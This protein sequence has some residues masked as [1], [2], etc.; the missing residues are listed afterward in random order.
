[1][2]FR[3]YS[4]S[5]TEPLL[6]KNENDASTIQNMLINNNLILAQT[7]DILTWNGNQWTFTGSIGF[8]GPSGPT[9]ANGNSVLN[10]TINP[11]SFIGVN[12]DFYINTT[13]NT[14][15]GPKSGNTWPPGVST[16][17]YTGSIGFTGPSGPTGTNGNSVLNGTVNPTSFIGVNGDFYIN[18]ATNTIFGPKSGSTWPLGILLDGPTG[19][20]GYATNTGATGP[21]GYT[22]STGPGY[23]IY[24]TTPA[25]SS[26]S[27]G[28]IGPVLGNK[29]VLLGYQAGL[30]NTSLSSDNVGIGYNSLISATSATGNIAIGSSAGQFITTGNNNILI[31]SNAE[32]NTTSYTTLNNSTTSNTLTIG[33]DQQRINIISIGPYNIMKFPVK[34]GILNSIT[35]S[36]LRINILPGEGI[37]LKINGMALSSGTLVSTFETKLAAKNIA[38]VITSSNTT[39][40]VNSGGGNP[41]ISTLY[42]TLSIDIQISITNT[43]NPTYDL[44][45]IVSNYSVS[46]IQIIQ[47]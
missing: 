40:S 25:L 37:G 23:R 43:G 22:G 45:I 46:N 35:T 12:E 24:G 4:K 27:G 21:T 13:T 26:V 33:S 17:G 31:G 39:S 16:E 8:T 7:G 5:S 38:G 29:N 32:I 20:T 15:F 36:F 18:T 30:A 3:V 9:G 47:I 28:N 42:N 19:P 44:G 2:S 14:I 10:G 6:T 41:V 1:M 34:T 11:T